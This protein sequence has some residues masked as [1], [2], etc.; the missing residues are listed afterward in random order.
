MG[1]NSTVSL[2]RKGGVAYH[3][4]ESWVLNETI[5]V[6]LGTFLTITLADGP[7]L[8]NNILFGSPYDED[9]YKKGAYKAAVHRSLV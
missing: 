7:G 8:Q 1:P 9:R 4:Q 2:P 6:H 3:A 5:R